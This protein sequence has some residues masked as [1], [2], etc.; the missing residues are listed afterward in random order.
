[1]TQFIPRSR[2][3]AAALVV[4]SGC[5]ISLCALSRET[6]PTHIGVAV[7][8]SSN[9]PSARLTITSDDS[10]APLVQLG[11]AALVRCTWVSWLS[12]WRFVSPRVSTAEARTDGMRVAVDVSEMALHVQSEATLRSNGATFDYDAVAQ[13]PTDSVIGMGVACELAGDAHALGGATFALEDAA[14]GPRAIIHTGRG[15]VVLRFVGFAGVAREQYSGAIRALIV[16]DR[17]TTERRRASIEVSLPSDG[18]SV[19]P[20]LSLFDRADPMTWPGTVQSPDDVGIDL[21]SLNEKPAGLHG[22]VR[23]VGENLVFADGTKTRFWGTNVQAYALFNGT[24]AAI[25]ATL[26]ALRKRG[27]SARRL[28]KSLLPASTSCASI[29]TTP[30]G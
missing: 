6:P 18:R 3:I 21:S 12:D 13:R 11:G 29:I 7:G 9:L 4:F 28:I 1:M 2:T 25:R 5:A 24:D 26:A 8:G 19:P 17:V 22:R 15:D 23:A 20:R 16:K 14:Q 10:G 27:I 30:V